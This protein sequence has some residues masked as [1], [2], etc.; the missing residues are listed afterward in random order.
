MVALEL[1][2]R[3]AS[4]LTL[5]GALLGAYGLIAPRNAGQLAGLSLGLGAAPYAPVRAV[6]GGILLMNAVTFT[7]LAEAP[8]IG[9]CLAAAVGAAWLGQAAGRAVSSLL[10][11]SPNRRQ[12]AL[13]LG[14]GVVGLALWGPLWTYLRLIREGVRV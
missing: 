13:L 14:E 9:S 11:R 4:L 3:L 1:W 2:L 10:S 12:I 6:C 8:R 5:L 7:A